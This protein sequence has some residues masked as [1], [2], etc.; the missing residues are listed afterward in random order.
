MKSIG[1][2]LLKHQYG[3]WRI[4]VYCCIKSKSRLIMQGQLLYWGLAHHVIET[5][6]INHVSRG[7]TQY[8]TAISPSRASLVIFLSNSS[9]LYVIFPW[10]N[11]VSFSEFLDYVATF[12][13]SINAVIYKY[14]WMNKTLRNWPKHIHWYGS[15]HGGTLSYNRCFFTIIY[16]A[17][18]INEADQ[19]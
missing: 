9:C 8:S 18:S 7:K 11:P 15:K 2:A 16:T 19:L 1:H 5:L 6:L 14:L 13:K 12:T 4:K 10:W 3:L 17:V